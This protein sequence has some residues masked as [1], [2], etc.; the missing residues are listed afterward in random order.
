MPQAKQTS[1]DT[2]HFRMWLGLTLLMVVLM[3]VVFAAYVWAEKRVDAVFENHQTSV[4]LSQ[5]SGLAASQLS[6]MA[7][8]YVTTGDTVYKKTYFTILGVETGELPRPA[9]FTPIHW[10]MVA[11]GLPVGHH[12]QPAVALEALRLGQG[13]TAAE[14]AQ[15]ER[16]DVHMAAMVATEQRAMRQYDQ[17]PLG[18][19]ALDVDALAALTSAS[20]R[21]HQAAVLAPLR[22]YEQAVEARTQAEVDRAI[23]QAES[24]RLSLAFLGVAT[25]W[26]TLR[27]GR[28][29]Y[30]L[31]GCTV[32][33]LQ[34]TI[35]RLGRGDFG[36][37]IEVPPG[38]ENS[39]LGWLADSQRRLASM[40]LRQYQALVQSSDDAIITKT[41][42][43]VVTSWNPG[44]ER[45]FGYSADD[46]VGEP[47]LTLF[48][49][50]RLAEEVRIMALIRAGQRVP[51][52][53]TLRRHKD[54]HL[55]EVS[56]TLS[57]IFNDQ[58]EVVGA[59]KIARDISERK[60]S[61]AL[62]QAKDV[63]ERAAEARTAFLANM[64]HELRTPMNAVLGFTRLL[65]DTRLDNEQRKHLHTIHTAGE[66]LLALLNDILDSAK[67]EHG[68]VVLERVEFDLNA[69]L[70]Q[71]E[72]TYGLSAGA[73]GLYL[74]VEQGPGVSSH[75]QGDSLRLGQVLTNLVGNAIKFTEKGGVTLALA[76]TDQGLHLRVSDTG[77]GM[78]Q[79]QQ[80]RLFAPFQQADESVARRF[81]GTGLGTYIS[82]QL[83]E[84]MGGRIW[85]DS[86][87]GAGSS[88]HVLVPLQAVEPVQDAPV[89]EL[90]IALPPLKVLVV[91]DVPVNLQLLG[92]ILKKDG[93]Q[94]TTAA[95]GDEAVALVKQGGFDMVLM[96]MQMPGMSGLEACEHI[97]AWE[98]AT[99]QAHTPIVA[100]TASV[101][102]ADREAAQRAGMDGFATKPVVL[103]H[104]RAEMALVLEVCSQGVA[105][106]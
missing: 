36:K 42:D 64:S 14:L 106:S 57:P 39:V 55:I 30:R 20:Y 21:E 69:L 63:A 9:R 23:Q 38:M 86:V 88:F 40:D 61:E 71:L 51:T 11:A 82:K 62:E 47:V 49:E 97:R 2:I 25:L 93:H 45:V 41:L 89:S 74:K 103:K 77:I 99:A 66:A 101:L 50:D 28:Q 94:V 15:L 33:R 46:M 104:L 12:D 76:Q 35:Q 67:L 85:V 53:E 10:D 72:A 73:K 65:L 31:L 44:A 19:P 5:E 56:V 102:L 52:F 87:P 32:P 83:V 43:G 80:V 98:L 91:D 37:P 26:V 79:E 75:Y 105:K 7:Y 96:D 29:L 13:F 18:A 92:L 24:L 100:M 34:N 95:D 54:G 4:A 60:R 84:L 16:A 78:T 81:G 27:M 17:R 68:A 48:P 90:H 22:A 58:H 1:R 6:R 59:S 3:L 8:Q 70:R